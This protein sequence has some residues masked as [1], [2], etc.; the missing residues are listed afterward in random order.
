MPDTR[1]AMRRF[2][3]LPLLIWS[4]E[5]YLVAPLSPEYAGQSWFLSAARPAIVQTAV[6]RVASTANASNLR[7]MVNL[8]EDAGVRAHLRQGCGGQVGPADGPGGPPLGISAMCG[9]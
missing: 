6:P 1:Q 5:E 3:T 8:L 2:L 7:R 9:V 4:R